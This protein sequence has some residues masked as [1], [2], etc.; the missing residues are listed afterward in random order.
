MNASLSTSSEVILQAVKYYYGQES[1]TTYVV[2]LQSIIAVND[3]N[4][5]GIFTYS[6]RKCVGGASR[7]IS[8]QSGA[9]FGDEEGM[10]GMWDG[11]AGGRR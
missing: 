11:F 7:R 9:D 4:A 8:E 3:L 1:I 6:D 2:R 10:L 5:T